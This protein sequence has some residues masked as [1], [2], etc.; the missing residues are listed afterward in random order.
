MVYI[1]YDVYIFHNNDPSWTVLGGMFFFKK[2]K[3]TSLVILE[4]LHS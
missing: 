4:F 3:K 1:W 2:E